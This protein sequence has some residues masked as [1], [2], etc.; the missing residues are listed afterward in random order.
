MIAENRSVL[1]SKI[2]LKA[3]ESMP[4]SR[5]ILL[6]ES[7]RYCARRLGC[8]QPC[9]HGKAIRIYNSVAATVDLEKYWN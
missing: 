2:R 4:W 3:K 1:E 6:G 7:S 8:A 9:R 5:P